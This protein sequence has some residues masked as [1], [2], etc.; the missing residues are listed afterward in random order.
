MLRLSL[1]TVQ[2]ISNLS[3]FK[4]W[5]IDYGLQVHTNHHQSVC[6]EIGCTVQ[7]SPEVEGIACNYLLSVTVHELIKYRDRAITKYS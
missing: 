4:N 2:C 6:L 7:S 5:I 3:L 1:Q